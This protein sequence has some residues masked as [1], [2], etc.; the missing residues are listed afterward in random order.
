VADPQGKYI[1]VNKHYLEMFGYENEEELFKKTVGELTHPDDRAS[2]REAQ[3]AL[4]RGETDFL[5]MEKRYLRKDGSFFW[6]EVSVSPIK[7]PDGTIGAFVAVINDITERKEAEAAMRESEERNR[8]EIHRF[9][10]R[11]VAGVREK[12]SSSRILQNRFL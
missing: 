3:M 10:D 7:D 2:T 6:G 9:P 1:R 8:Q 5:R 12:D 11:G 4:V